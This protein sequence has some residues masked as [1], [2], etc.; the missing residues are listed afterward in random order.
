MYAY[1]EN[2][3]TMKNL[4]H[5]WKRWALLGWFDILSRYRRTF[6]GPLWIVLMTF[7]SV[8]SIG[9]VYSNIFNFPVSG[10]INFVALG[11]I[12]WTL[13]STALIESCT[14]FSTYKFILFNHR[15]YPSSLIVRIVS[16]NLYIFFH[17]CL[18]VAFF[19]IF[20]KSPISWNCLLT[21]PGILIVAA[22]IFSLS[23][24]LAF[25]CARFHDLSQL[26]SSLMGLFFLVTPVIWKPETLG[27]RDY[28]A[29]LN[30][31]THLIALI[32]QP[33][34]GVRPELLD[35]TVSVGLFIM[36]SFFA[37]IITR[38]FSSKVLLWI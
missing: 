25:A 16:R 9:F 35:W 7:I 19:I 36:F 12:I 11:I 6:F 1:F 21:I 3:E 26:V 28:I 33:I 20:F 13:M 31:L 15:I 8:S 37:W 34:L 4:I 32:R 30:P 27:H 23:I 2:L 38:T 17:N 14:A 22:V 18:V 10:F 24:F 5:E 29:Q